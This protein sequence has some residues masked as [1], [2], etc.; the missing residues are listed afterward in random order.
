MLAYK[1]WGLKKIGKETGKTKRPVCSKIFICRNGFGPHEDASETADKTLGG[2]LLCGKQTSCNWPWQTQIQRE[3][4][5]KT[6]IFFK[7]KTL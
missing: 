4:D 3:S 6:W 7:E 2:S 5:R 1:K